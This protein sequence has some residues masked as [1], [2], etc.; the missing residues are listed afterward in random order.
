LPWVAA[1][2][3]A[4]H[5]VQV[6]SVAWMT[7][8]KNTLSGFLY[9]LSALWY[10]EFDENREKRCYWAA[11][12][13]FVLAL[14]S[15]SVTATLPAALL[16][17]IWWR[18]GRLDWRKDITPLMPFFA[19]GI[20]A[21]L[22]TSWIET[23]MIGAQGS[24]Y[25]LDSAQKFLLAGRVV[26]FYLGKLIWPVN[27][28]FI[29]PRWEISPSLWWQS[30]YPVAL[31]A[32]VLLL[33]L[34]RKR[35]RGPLAATL[36]FCGTLFPVL[37]FFNVYPFRYSF[38]ADHFQ[39]LACIGLIALLVSALA[40]FDEKF[41]LANARLP[42]IVLVTI[43]GPLAVF[44]GN[45]SRVYAD[46]DTLYRATLSRNPSCWMAH[47][48]LGMSL[49]SRGEIE[50]AALHYREALRLEPNLPET[51]CNLGNVLERLGRRQ[52]AIS[53]YEQALK[54]KPD[55]VE[56]LSNLG[57]VLQETGRLEE[58]VARYREALR[59]KPNFAVGHN[60]LG[61][62][63][64]S[65]GHFQEAIVEYEAAL[66]LA[67]GYADAMVGLAK[68]REALGKGKLP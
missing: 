57:I 40:A 4:L 58:A 41:K 33:W 22:A 11:L 48:N 37:G 27:L 10:L 6:E 29:Y 68:S 49:Q 46:G 39:Y 61:Y 13:L 52:E 62:A 43:A 2:I 60:N 44:T 38:V 30:L 66:R 54:L 16:V 20:V 18:C 50:E 36:F 51:R 25:V 55:L 24:E 56:A 23:N 32:V 59:L 53:E 35:S 15:K 9:L 42:V 1:A 3:F 14:L 12:A 5:P 31:I 26:W 8:L 28:A 45:Q 65:M 67:P 21:G 47:N 34:S 64:Q 7:E 19:A 17:V 63:L